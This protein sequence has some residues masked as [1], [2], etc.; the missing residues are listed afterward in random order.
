MVPWFLF[1]PLL[2]KNIT[3]EKLVVVRP[4][5]TLMGVDL[6]RSG[7][8]LPLGPFPTFSIT[9]EKSLGMFKHPSYSKTRQKLDFG[10]FYVFF[11]PLREE[12]KNKDLG[13]VQCLPVRCAFP[14]NSLSH[15]TG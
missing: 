11:F 13:V 14:S 8:I 12:G 3:L 10:Q 4:Q 2:S 5:I 1:Q 9:V 6:A 15:T 7:H